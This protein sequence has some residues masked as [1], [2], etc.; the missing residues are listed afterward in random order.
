M[1]RII[2]RLFNAMMDLIY[3]ILLASFSRICKNL[4]IRD[5]K[6]KWLV[7]AGSNNSSATCFSLLKKEFIGLEYAKVLSSGFTVHRVFLGFPRSN[8]TS[9]MA[10]AGSLFPQPFLSPYKRM[11]EIFY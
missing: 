2:F 7:A 6:S 4:I 1:C 8:I 10:L 11:N 9:P 3:C 5:R